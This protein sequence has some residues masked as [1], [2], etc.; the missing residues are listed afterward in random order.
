MASSAF[1]LE[2]IAPKDVVV[3]LWRNIRQKERVKLPFIEVPVVVQQGAYYDEI[4][5]FITAFGSLTQ[6]PVQF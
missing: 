3:I 5:D 6:T 4:S 1:P 2:N